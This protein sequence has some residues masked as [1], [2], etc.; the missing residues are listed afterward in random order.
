MDKVWLLV[1]EA[2]LTCTYMVVSVGNRGL[3][4]SNVYLHS[5]ECGYSS[6]GRL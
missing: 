2:V 6:L 1:D 5:I 4:G 3:G